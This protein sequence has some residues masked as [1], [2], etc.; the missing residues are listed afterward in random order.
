MLLCG[1]EKDVRHVLMSKMVA[2]FS[3]C[4]A[5]DVLPHFV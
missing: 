1:R 4:A 2:S 3:D 5:L